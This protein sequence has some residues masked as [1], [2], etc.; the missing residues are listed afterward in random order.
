MKKL[1]DNAVAQKTA[2]NLTVGSTLTPAQ[3]AQLT[4]DI[5]WY[6]TTR[7]TMPDGSIK[8]VLKPQLYLCTATK[9]SLTYNPDQGTSSIAATNINILDP[10]TANILTNNTS[11]PNGTLVVNNAGQIIASQGMNMIAKEVNNIGQTTGNGVIKSNTTNLITSGDIT[12]S[13]G[14]II[15]D[16]NLNLVST[17]GNILSQTLVKTQ[18]LEKGGYLE[19]KQ[20]ELGMGKDF[21][22]TL[23]QEA[24][25]KSTN[26]DFDMNAKQ[27][28]MLIGSEINAKNNV[29]IAT[30]GSFIATTQTTSK[31]STT[32]SGYVSNMG[33]KRVDEI[34]INASTTNHASNINAAN[35]NINSGYNTQTGTAN[36]TSGAGI[37][38]QG[39]NFNIINTTNLNSSGNT[40]ILSAK[41]TTTHIHQ[42]EIHESD[43]WALMGSIIGG[44]ALGVITGGSGIVA[45]AG[46]G[47]GLLANKLTGT[48][49]IN[50]DITKTETNVASNINSDTL[51]INSGLDLNGN[52]IQNNPQNGN[53][54]IV[55]SN[56]TTLNALGLTAAGQ[57]N[58][59]SSQNT[60]FHLHQD[61]EQKHDINGI[62]VA[63]S[64]GAGTGAATG[65]TVGAGSGAVVGAIAGAGVGAG[66]GAAIGALFGGISGAIG[67]LISGF[68][69]GMNLMTTKILTTTETITNAIS[70]NINTGGNIDLTSNAGHGNDNA[71]PNTVNN[72]NDVTVLGSNINTSQTL[73]IDTNGNNFNKLV[74]NNIQ[75]TTE[76]YEKHEADYGKVAADSAIENAITGSISGLL[77]GIMVPIAAG[78]ISLNVIKTGLSSTTIPMSIPYATAILGFGSG[79]IPFWSYP[80]VTVTR[81]II[82][83]G[84]G[85]ALK[86]Y[87]EIETD[88]HFES[89]QEN[90]KII[91]KIESN[92]NANNLI[93]K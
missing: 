27:N 92:I 24:L 70:S 29:N 49:A 36:T 21:F 87:T 64:S 69:T 9:E 30:E 39:S 56:L 93:L 6:V 62:L 51:N 60:M 76:K 66:P 19:K 17:Q 68:T 47:T 34:D 10:N 12:N 38:V 78:N 45:V 4:S 55:G 53:I 33:F 31:Q 83:D 59:L 67:G 13:S 61:I 37:F 2:L 35:L 71:L 20:T 91:S 42:T 81:A 26:G 54:N 22:Q 89:N 79:V 43:P 73:T 80:V 23:G 77:S 85:Y 72:K 40:S 58:I 16:S 86:D 8:Q 3:Q 14:L 65:A 18:Y 46:V 11:N 74:A 44:V 48:S 84:I 7:I 52:L 32:A 75:T 50:T 15:S 82:A 63:M 88:S 5:V 1:L 28:T 57:T 90:E 41:D 25:I